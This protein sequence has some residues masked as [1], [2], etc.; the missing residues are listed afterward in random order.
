M[1]MKVTFWGVRGS[2]PV[3]GT[4]TVRY[5]G[6]TSCVQVEIEG[7]PPLILDA[8]TGL[9]ACGRRLMSGPCGKGEGTV[10]LFLTH[11]HWDHVQGLPYFNPVFTRGNRLNVW[12]RSGRGTRIA[13]AIGF[14]ASEAVFPVQFDE[15]PANFRFNQIRPDEAITAGGAEV[16]PIPLNHPGKATGFR[17]SHGGKS[18]AYIT[19]TSPFDRIRYKRHFAKGPPKRLPAGDRRIL[20][21]MRK[22]LVEAVRDCD[23]LIFDTTFTDQEYEKFPHWGHSTP[24]QALELAREAGARR[25]MLFHHAPNRTDEQMDELLDETRSRAADT[26]VMVDAASQ[27]LA[28]DI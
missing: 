7:R 5:G 15:M 14:V 20:T 24:W 8:G 10:N 2:Y 22:H 13:D 6:H 4:T 9:R 12:A 16:L 1:R 27:G 26:G 18:V 25:L 19:D 21:R 17:V 28:V 23:L 11:L 3:A